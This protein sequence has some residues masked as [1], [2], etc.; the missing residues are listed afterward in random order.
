MVSTRRASSPCLYL[1][2]GGFL[3]FD[4]D[5][6]YSGKSEE[7]EMIWIVLIYYFKEHKKYRKYFQEA[8]DVRPT[9]SLQI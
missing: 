1:I 2:L 4:T 5:N 6:V 3:L 7:E 9:V 8:P